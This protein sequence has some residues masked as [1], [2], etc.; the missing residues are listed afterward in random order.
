MQPFLSKMKAKRV[1]NLPLFWFK[2]LE[3]VSDLL[4]TTV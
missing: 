1:Y 3:M 2:R 4:K